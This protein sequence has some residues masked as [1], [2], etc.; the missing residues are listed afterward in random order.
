MWP[1]AVR[2]L[3]PRDLPLASL[4]LGSV[5]A[6][7]ACSDK[8]P[9]G[10]GAVVQVRVVPDTLHVIL[11]R[12]NTA[13]AFPLDGVG[14][15]LPKK[16][17][18]WAT[19]D[20]GIASVN[21]SGKVTGLALG[22]T[23]IS[24]TSSGVTGTAVVI[25]DPVPT[26]VLR[27]DT[28]RISGIAASPTGVSGVDSVTNGGG[29][30]IGGLVVDSITYPAA[31]G[32]WLQAALTGTFAPAQVDL[33][34]NPSTLGLGSHLALVWVSSPD[35]TP[36]DAAI[37]VLLTL[38]SDVAASIA[39][40]GGSGQTATVNTA[41]TIAPSVLVRDQFN[42]PVSGVAVN[43]AVA[44]GGGAVTGGNA[45][46]N[47]SGVA[48]VGS[49]TLGTIAGAN[50]LT[51]SAGGLA[52]SPV[53]FTATGTAGPAAQ[54]TVNAGNNQAAIAGTPVSVPPSA[55]VGDQFGN[56]VSGVAVTFAVGS[57][58]GSIT[59][60]N[61]VT[62]ASG[63]ATVG[64]WTLGA[65]AGPNT[66]TASSAGLA[67]TPVIFSAT[68]NPG[69][70]TNMAQ[71]SGDGQNA[72]VNTAVG[73]PYV[74]R[75]ADINN[76]PVQGVTVGW[77][78]S[79]GGSMNPA[80]SQT[81]VNGL[82]SSTHT[83]GTTAGTQTATAAV[84]GLIG[85]PVTFTATANP[86]TATQIAVSAGTGQTATV[87]TAVTTDPAA[88]ARDAFNNPVPGVVITYSI[89]TGAGSVNCGAGN[90]AS[91]TVTTNAS[92]VATVTS[93]TVGTA[94][95][96]NNNTLRGALPG[97]ATF[98]TFTAS[99]TPGAVASV[100]IF[101]G[102]NLE[103]RVGTAVATDPA[104]QLRDAFTNVVPGATVTFT[105]TSGGNALVNCGLGNTTSCTATSNA[106][107]IATTTAFIMNS[108]GVP[109]AGAPSNGRYTNTLSATSNAIATSFTG[110]G[111][112]SFANDVQPIFTSRCVG[113]HFTGGTAPNLSAGSA[114]AA[115]RNVF[116]FSCG[117][118]VAVGFNTAGSSFL[119]NKIASATPCSGSQMPADGTAPMAPNLINTIR[120]WINNNS[121]N[122]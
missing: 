67:G 51:A 121:P 92:G 36:R 73:A 3:R 60:P 28:A 59:G 35:A 46:T 113:C 88:I 11:G 74:V 32:G 78:A 120:D 33:T 39:Q 64:S 109:T 65:T 50:T 66:L 37:P 48:T 43:F 7:L 26:M 118:Y 12:N 79:G 2:R 19:Q 95:G 97:G 72:T 47:A 103:A 77:A 106:S 13:A 71:S 83:L 61:Q 41:V 30:S 63:V 104:V 45:T 15:F 31:P 6:G 53:T 24:A 27:P 116:S 75:V 10:P 34:A 102:N 1:A 52:G 84:G 87:N 54:I 5:L 9:I 81:D 80:S 4:L 20:A 68:G 21:D 122:N 99:A 56:A 110:F 86:G 16:S 107:G 25:V 29:G 90:V 62:N 44:G 69:N 98:T 105:I 22:T 18:T 58:G 115:I 8:S 101:A 94:A 100:T 82:A 114:Y 17:V 96:T 112:F 111:I 117:A 42:N 119:F 57:G 38:T 23:K 93:W 40:A 55:K 14:A 108:S 70:A 76:N 49:W 91:C 89:Q 85:S